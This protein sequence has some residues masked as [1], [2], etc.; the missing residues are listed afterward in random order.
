MDD[1][2][3]QETV[4]KRLLGQPRDGGDAS[5]RV[6][7]VGDVDSY[8]VKGWGYVASLPG[9]RVILRNPPL[10]FQRRALLLN[11]EISSSRAPFSEKEIADVMKES[12]SARFLELNTKAFKLGAETFSEH[13]VERSDNFTLN[14]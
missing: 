13:I 6:V 2:S 9:E 12:I 7:S 3:F 4:R 14:A 1:A 5:Q 10:I 8:L 11:R